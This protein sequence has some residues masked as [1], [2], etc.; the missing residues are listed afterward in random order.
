MSVALALGRIDVAYLDTQIVL[1]DLVALIERARVCERD[2]HAV[3]AGRLIDGERPFEAM[4]AD[5]AGGAA[6]GP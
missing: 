6:A 3:A 5:A 2:E 1:A 4:P